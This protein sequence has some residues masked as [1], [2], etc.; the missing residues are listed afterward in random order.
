MTIADSKAVRQSD[1]VYAVGYP[2]GLANTLSDGIVSSRYIDEYGNDIIQVTAAISEGNSGGPLLNA[3]G[4]VIGVMCAYYIYGQNL[5]IAIASDAL[6]ALLGSEYKKTELKDWKDRPAMP[7]AEAEIEDPQDPDGQEAG[8]SSSENTGSESGTEP[9][10]PE[11]AGVDNP[12]GESKQEE[13]PQPAVRK[14]EEILQGAWTQE[15]LDSMPSNKYDY[16]EFSGNHVYYESYYCS[17]DAEFILIYAGTFTIDEGGSL[18]FHMTREEVYFA[19]GRQEVNDALDADWAPRPITALSQD[20]YT[21]NGSLTYHRTSGR[22]TKLS[23][24]KANA[25]STQSSAF[26][27]LS[28]WITNNSNLTIGEDKAYQEVLT[29]EDFREAYKVTYSAG[30]NQI[31]LIYTI[32]YDSGLSFWAFL[33]LTPTGKSF[34]STFYQYDAVASVNIFK[35][36]GVV[37]APSFNKNSVFTF[38][39]YEGDSTMLDTHQSAAKLMYLESLNFLNDLFYTYALPSGYQFSTSDFG[40]NI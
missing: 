24:W 3:D 22:P 37:H 13:P 9:E 18:C 11:A 31:C 30:V 39:S 7:D 21:T 5:N 20:S 33:W 40:F 38:D 19:D 1:V 8:E 28:E 15:P 10:K 26:S 29:G 2:L 6:E 32:D 27:F 4:Q 35:G 23:E 12:P 17:S 16:F 14:P 36:S 25:Q 34:N